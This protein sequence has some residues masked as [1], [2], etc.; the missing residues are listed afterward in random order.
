LSRKV[1]TTDVK[2]IAAIINAAPTMMPPA[3]D[4]AS[5]AVAS[6]ADT[7]ATTSPPSRN[8]PSQPS[9]ETRNA[10]KL[11]TQATML[12]NSALTGGTPCQCTSPGACQNSSDSG[13]Y[14]TMESHIA[15]WNAGSSATSLLS[16]AP[17]RYTLANC[18]PS[19]RADRPITARK[20][21]AYRAPST[22]MARVADGSSISATAGPT[23]G[24]MEA[25]D[26]DAM[27]MKNS[28]AS[29]M[30]CFQNVRIPSLTQVMPVRAGTMWSFM[31]VL[32]KK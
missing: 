3:A 26:M 32:L 30:G 31:K 19:I 16:W 20:Q 24:I 17:P 11:R 23:S 21:A 22:I 25:S 7:S 12:K 4:A 27:V 9:P 29:A 15:L 28:A 13:R 6:S 18:P 8:T 14:S 1:N 2:N 10:L 5:P